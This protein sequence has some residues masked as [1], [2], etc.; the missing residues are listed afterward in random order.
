MAQ[1][2]WGQV[3]YSDEFAGIIQEEPGDRYSFTYDKTYSEK[4]YPAVSHCLPLQDSPHISAYGLHPFFDNLVAE[5][6]LENA[7]KR[8]LGKREASRFSLLLGFGFDCAGAVSVRDP[9]PAQTSDKL[10]NLDDPREHAILASRASL[11]GIQP[12][13]AVRKEGKKFFPCHWNELST[14]I[15]KFSSETH[16]NILENEF[17]CTQIH[18]I[19]LPGDPVVTMEMRL[20]EG[21]E[22]SAL[23]I[24]RFDRSPQGRI[25]FEEFNQLLN[26]KSRDKYEGSH[27]AMAD[28][29]NT[30]PGCIP[31]ETYRLFGRILAGFLLGNTDMHLKNFAMIHTSDGLRLTPAYDIVGASSYGYK[32]IALEINQAKDLRLGDLKAR[33]IIALGRAFGLPDEAIALKTHELHSRLEAAKDHISEAVIGGE[34]L[35]NHLIETLEKRWNG[36]FALIGQTLSK[37]P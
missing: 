7:Q 30:T 2:A 11:S 21:I 27:E 34:S 10:L 25:H 6:W 8:A 14:H 3:F 4:K 33:H 16:P 37:K 13:M 32:T 22:S 23:I 29:I 24:E 31:A 17:L 19:L 12:K 35:K 15:A 9:E 28:F 20:V 36:T 26:Q 1:T 5:G 18:K